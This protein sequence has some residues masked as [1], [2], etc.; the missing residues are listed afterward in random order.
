MTTIPGREADVTYGGCTMKLFLDM[1]VGI[2][3][4][5]WPAAENFCSLITSKEYITFFRSLISGRRV[6]E[7]GSGNGLVGILIDKLFQPKEM[8]ITDHPSHM[9]HIE[10]NVIQ[11]ECASTT[12]SLAYDWTGSVSNLGDAL[13]K[14][15]DVIMALECV[16]REDLY[17][18]LIRAIKQ[19]S[20]K[21]TICFL[22]STRQFTKPLF[23]HM[24]EQNGLGY[25]KLP[26]GLLEASVLDENTGERGMVAV[27]T[28][29]IMPGE[30]VMEEKEPLLYFS[31]ADQ[32]Q[33]QT[34]FASCFKKTRR[35]DAVQ[36]VGPKPLQPLK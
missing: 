26:V 30:L 2:G 24:L 27:A 32:V 1:G 8:C 29:D 28:R 9:K 16:Y 4:D 31:Q 7:L 14:P 18:P 25:K 22:G 13:Q 5:K 17:L 23:F 15:F 6:L 11:N 10:R 19:Q 21:N 33:F 20:H 36:M 34:I 35:F 3:G 12:F